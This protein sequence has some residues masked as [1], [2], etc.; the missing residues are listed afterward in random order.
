PRKI[1][2]SALG[3]DILKGNIQ[4]D[5]VS[6]GDQLPFRDG[7]LDYVV[8]SRNLQH[9]PDVQKTLGE[10]KRVLKK[11]GILGFVVPDDRIIDTLSLNPQHQHAFTP[12][13][14][15]EI[16]R[17]SGGLEIEVLQEVVDAWSFGCICRKTST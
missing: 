7:A 4:A 10:W 16:L 11:D 14:L 3:I 12:E 9:Y 17:Q 1:S 15:K 6:S 2:S 5:L 8:A 13:L